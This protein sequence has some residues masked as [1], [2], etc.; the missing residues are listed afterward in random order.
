VS[1][2][3]KPHEPEFIPEE[4]LVPEDDA[5]IGVAAKWSLIA[6]IGLGAAIGVIYLVTRDRVEPPKVI[7]RGPIVAPER[8]EHAAE[9]MPS[10]IFTDITSASGIDFVH[11]SGAKGEKLL[12]ETMGGGCAFLDFDNNGTQDILFVNSSHWPGEQGNSPAPTMRLYSNDGTGQFSDVTTSAGLNITAYGMGAATGDFDND[13]HVDIFLANLGSNILLR[14]NGDGTFSDVTTRAGV[15]GADDMWSTSAGFF[16]YNN[17][18]RLDLFVCNYVE[19]SREIDLRLNFTLNGVDRAYGPPKLYKGVN[20]YLYQNQG[21]GTFKDVSKGAGIHVANPALGEPV[22]KALAVTFCDV[23]HDGWIDIF[24]ANDTV[25]NFL[26][27][28]NGDGTFTEQGARS[29][30]AFDAT[31]AATGAM[32]MDVADYRNDGTIAVAI[33]NFANESSS[34]F[35]QQP[36][37]PWQFADVAGAEGFGSPSRLRLSFG[38]FFF[39]A[40]LDGRMDLFQANGHLE[41]EIQEIQSSQTYHQPAQLFWNCGPSRRG[42]YRLIPDEKAG[43]L[44]RP[45][46]GRGAAYADIDGDGDLDILITQTGDKPLLLRN[47]QQL[48]HH[49]LRIKLV[50]MRSNKDA[51]GAVIE[52]KSSGSLQRKQVMPTRSYLSQ[53]ELPVTFGLGEQATVESLRIIW[54]DGSTQ[55]VPVA[56]VDTTM[57]I[58]QS[59]KQP[60]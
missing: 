35:A 59:E 24:V 48:G 6:V 27:R 20:S 43:D 16:D 18:G 14:N 29:G 39:D 31:G 21:D 41:D 25:Q 33:G 1:D 19:W 47:D 13:G 3:T 17:D 55:E 9:S 46:V 26:F 11:V 56:S 42:C 45:L 28:N 34:L 57:T 38:L 7:E 12:P 37:Q 50:G 32:G 49:W 8:M 5:I 2:A 36:N 4:E 44:V 15:A 60:S 10:I 54:P 51:I 40:D 22:G 58:T 52:L 23:D 53:V 30:V